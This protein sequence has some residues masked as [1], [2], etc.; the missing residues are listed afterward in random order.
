MTRHN[1]L[2]HLEYSRLSNHLED[3]QD[4][5]RKIIDAAAYLYNCHSSLTA[6]MNFFDVRSTTEVIVWGGEVYEIRH[7]RMGI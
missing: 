5:Q 6:P 7:S 2:V 3:I 4:E 1:L